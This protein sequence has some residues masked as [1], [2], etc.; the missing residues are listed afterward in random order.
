M[1]EIG[2]EVAEGVATLSLLAPQRR[3]AIDPAMAAE[4]VD[5]CERID[6]DPSIGAVVVRGDGGHFCAGGDRATLAAAGEDPATGE[7]WDGLSTVYRSF[8]RVG[9]LAPPTIAAVQGSAVGAGVNLLL[10]TDLRIVATDARIMSGFQRIGLHP[11]GGHFT[12]LTR[13]AGREAAAALGVFGESVDGARAV[14]LGLAWEA[15]PAHE[16]DDRARELAVRTAA[17][18]ELA[19]RTVA[20]LR[21]QAGARDVPWAVAL[22]AERAPQMW[23]MRRKALRE[24]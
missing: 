21:T 20:S 18:P 23:S 6:A 7:A 10:A 19:R 11:G 2:L 8:T 1:T 15:L 16:V 13:L 22:D 14:E 24:A 5:A 4:L 9:E 12:L 3:N 17:D